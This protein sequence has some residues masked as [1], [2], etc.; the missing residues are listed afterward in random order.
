M[1]DNNNSHQATK[2]ALDAIGTAAKYTPGGA[3]ANYALNHTDTDK[4]IKAA[5]E[6]ALN[7]ALSAEPSGDNIKVKLERDDPKSFTKHLRDLQQQS[8]FLSRMNEKGFVNEDTGSSIVLRANG[9]INLAASEQAQ[10]KL[11]PNGE[12]TEIAIESNTTANRKNF[13]ID[14]MVINEHKL[15]P[16]LY[17]LTDMREVEF[18][19]G[20]TGTVGNFTVLGTVLVKAWEPQLNRYMLIRRLCRLPMFSNTLNTPDIHKGIH[21]KDPFEV[22]EEILALSSKGYQVNAEIKDAKSFIGKEGKNRFKIKDDEDDT[23]VKVTGGA[24]T[25]AGGGHCDSK[26]VE[27][28]LQWCIKIASEPGHAY[29]QAQRT[30]PNYDCTSFISSG[31]DQAGAGC[32]VLG[33]EAFD[34][35]IMKCG[36]EKID[37]G[38]LGGSTEHVAPPTLKRGDILDCDHH[39]E[40]YLGSNQVVG[41][42]STAS[43]IS[44]KNYW[45][46]GWTHVLRCT[47]K[48]NPESDD[49]KDKKDGDKKDGDKKDGDKKSEG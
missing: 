25:A 43:G 45:Y 8:K 35:G 9:E 19:L 37:W 48:D 2:K 46:D 31:L 4:K 47:V 23:R 21:V 24:T 30:G 34:P 14:E 28:A 13:T 6:D 12:A 27:A 18:P 26:M 1:A 16:A 5:A 3:V 32:G 11:N 42:H 22:D 39:V 41:A 10:Y 40:F 29:S 36:F 33:G 49:N 44:V 17:E 7:D 38:T 15:N 20:T